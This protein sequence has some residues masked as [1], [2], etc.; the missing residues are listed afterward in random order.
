MKASKLRGLLKIVVRDGCLRVFYKSV[1]LT[2]DLI[3]ALTV[4]WFRGIISYCCHKHSEGCTNIGILTG[5]LKSMDIKGRFFYII[6]H[7]NVI[8][9]AKNNF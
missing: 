9:L 8:T 3:A 2:S 4:Q 6:L 5:M 1:E 7:K